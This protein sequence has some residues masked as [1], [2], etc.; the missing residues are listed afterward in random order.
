MRRVFQFEDYV[1]KAEKALVVVLIF[2]MVGMSFTQVLLRFLLHSG[3]VWLDPLM[4]HMVVWAGLTGAALAAR[5]SSHF[6]LEAFVKFAPRALRRPLEILAGIFTIA[7]S[8][9]LFY[10]AYKF[11]KDEFTAGSVAFYIN[12]LAVSAGWSEIIMPAA[13]ALI[14]F[15]TLIG[16]FRERVVAGESGDA[17]IQ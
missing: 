6:A 14:A 16:L 3:I 5:Y 13:F 1:V 2:A 9:L 8:L 17:V 12:R 7:A 11:I 4:R 10:A 15:H